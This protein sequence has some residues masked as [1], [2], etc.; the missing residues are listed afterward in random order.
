MKAINVKL[1]QTKAKKVLFATRKYKEE[2]EVLL[3]LF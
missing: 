1:H 2:P 3:E